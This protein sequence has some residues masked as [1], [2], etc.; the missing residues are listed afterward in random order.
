MDQL[1]PLPSKE[2]IAQ[3]LQ[4]IRERFHYRPYYP[5]RAPCREE[6]LHCITRRREANANDA[7]GSWTVHLM[8]RKIRYY[9][10]FSDSAYGGREA[11][12]EA[13]RR[14]RDELFE[15]VKPT[16]RRE[17]H[18]VLMKSNTSGVPGV[19]ILKR[20]GVPHSWR[21]QVSLYGKAQVRDFS[22]TKY[23]D[24]HAFA[25]AVKAR[26]AMVDD[27]EGNF[28]NNPVSRKLAKAT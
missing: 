8:R 9:K 27:L 1:A 21:A 19:M 16:S 11:A 10:D 18:S 4:P 22:I 7:G 25:L 15:T 13:A 17:R 26:A 14:Y 2:D 5:G 24:E 3:L 28:L 23:G 6:A 12:L 20:K